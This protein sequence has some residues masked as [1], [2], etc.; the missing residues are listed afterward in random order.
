MKC[1]WIDRWKMDGRSC[2]MILTHWMVDPE[3]THPG[4]ECPHLFVHLRFTSN[5][6]TEIPH[7]LSG[8]LPVSLSVIR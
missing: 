1:R 4:F 3:I 5:T 8:T 7:V 6:L 2:A